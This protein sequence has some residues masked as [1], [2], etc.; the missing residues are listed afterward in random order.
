MLGCVSIGVNL[1]WRVGFVFGQ[2]RGESGLN[3]TSGGTGRTAQRVAFVAAMA[4]RGLVLVMCSICVV[5]EMWMSER[6]NLE[7][8]DDEENYK[9]LEWGV[10]LGNSFGLGEFVRE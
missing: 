9:T 5:V 2:L 10:L 1:V 3:G 8:G 4:L 7:D 6:E